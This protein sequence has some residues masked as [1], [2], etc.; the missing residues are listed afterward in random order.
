MYLASDLFPYIRFLFGLRITYL[1]VNL[2]TI[3]AHQSLV[4]TI[5][6]QCPS[7]TNA[8][9]CCDDV[10]PDEFPPLLQRKTI[11]HQEAACELSQSCGIR[12]FAL[13]STLKS[14]MVENLEPFARVASPPDTP[15]LPALH[16]LEIWPST[17]EVAIALIGTLPGTSLASINIAIL[18]APTVT[19]LS[20]L[21]RMLTENLSHV[22][23]HSIHIYANDPE[24]M[25]PLSA[26][27]EQHIVQAFVLRWLFCFPNLTTL[28]LHTTDPNRP[29]PLLTNSICVSIGIAL[30][31]VADGATGKYV[32][33][34]AADHFDVLLLMSDYDHREY[35]NQTSK[36]N[37]RVSKE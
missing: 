5:A 16:D 29:I 10:G 32:R 9:L 1:E 37:Q 26:T 27:P 15:R 21:Y 3:T 28:L 17:A 7:L 13:L 24:D 14:L 19:A 31:V 11:R 2:P 4:P 34:N 30:V 8:T 22:T 20:S 18:A 25:A 35:L 6:V 33:I 12:A 36:K 23:L